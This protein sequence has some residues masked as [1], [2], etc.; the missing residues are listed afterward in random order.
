MKMTREDVGIEVEQPVWH[1]AGGQFWTGIRPSLRGSCRRI[2]SL[3]DPA[4]FQRLVVNLLKI[5]ERE[6]VQIRR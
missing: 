2:L 5:H 6:P 3:F 4:R 1:F